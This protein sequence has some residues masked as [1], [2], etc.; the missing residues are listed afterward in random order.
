MEKPAI[1]I[2]AAGSS[3]RLGQPKQLLSHTNNSLLYYAASE[4]LK[5]TNNVV[6]VLGSHAEMIQEELKN[7]PVQFLHNKDWKEGMSSSIRNGLSFLLEEMPQLDAV[8][9][10]VSDQPF[11]SASL[12]NDIIEKYRETKKPVV[13]CSYKDT[14][15]VPALFD[16]SLFDD[17]LQLSGPSGAKKIIAQYIDAVDIIA[18]P[19]G[20]I[21]I[22]TQEDYEAF[23]KIQSSN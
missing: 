15:G 4:A 11:V 6:V 1:L 22:D 14:V 19:L 7:L 8:M 5:T 18:F 16:K 13:A 12:L 20:Y 23:K 17:L 3:Q 2:L 9:I 10:M 21:D